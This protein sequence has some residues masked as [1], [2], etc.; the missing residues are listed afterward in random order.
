VTALAQDVWCD[1][2]DARHFMMTPH[3]MLGGNTPA[4]HSLT[5]LGA[6]EVEG[7]L[8]SIAFGLCV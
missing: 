4:E 5:D 1:A 2:A 6:R 8:H 3:P 7:I